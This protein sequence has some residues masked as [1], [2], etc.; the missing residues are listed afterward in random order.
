MKGISNPL[1]REKVYRIVIY[2]KDRISGTSRD[3]VYAVDLP[4]FIQ[5]I[6]RYHV[7]VEDFLIQC[8]LSPTNIG[9]TLLV[10]AS[11]TQPDTY[12]TS[13]RSA[14]RVLFTISRNTTA[15]ASTSY[16]KT[17]TSK[18]Y[19]IPLADVSFLRSKQLNL[20]LKQVD[21]TVHTDLTLGVTNWVMTL[22]V[23]PFI[24]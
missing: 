4:D 16:Y 11:M 24:A 13:S 14:S 12:S 17:V 9:R 15:Q 7:A 18:T 22:V 20:T 2:S 8:E 21:D 6:N 19:G 23:Y 5:D 10:E 1:N 3:G